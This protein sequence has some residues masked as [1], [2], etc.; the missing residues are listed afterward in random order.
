MVQ[1]DE[2]TVTGCLIR[3]SEASVNPAVLERTILRP[4]VREF[5]VKAVLVEFL[6]G[7]SASADVVLKN[8]TH[9]IELDYKALTALMEKQPR[10]G[11]VIMGEL[12]RIE[13]RRLRNMNPK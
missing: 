12:A 2:Y 9:L 4:V 5:P 7:L 8:E 3:F 10:L 11:Y 1:H 6:D 13:A